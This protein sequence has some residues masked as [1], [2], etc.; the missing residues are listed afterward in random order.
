M[1]RA[2]VSAM[3]VVTFAL[4]GN[5]TAGKVSM[6][7]EG[8]F[9]FVFCAADQAKIM[10]VSD[11]VFV[12]HYHGIANVLTNPPGRPFDRSSAVCYGIYAKFHGKEQGF[13]VCE[14]IDMDGDKWWM[15]YHGS[16]SGGGGSYTSPHGTGKYEGMTMKGEYRL[17][18]WPTSKD[19]A[20]QLCNP[21]KGTYKLK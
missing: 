1:M 6:P 18:F 15:E 2:F 13:G 11:K 21:N 5:V 10:S 9:E 19:A 16:P 20:L 17:E 14:V 8:N 4:S 7:K 3:A 12:S